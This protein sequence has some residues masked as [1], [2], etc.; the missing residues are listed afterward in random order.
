MSRRLHRRQRGRLSMPVMALIA[1]VT[2][3]VCATAIACTYFLMSGNA[4]ADDGAHSQ[5]ESVPVPDPVFVA[6]KPLTINLAGDEGR[7]LYVGMSLM[8]DNS[9]AAERVEAYMPQIRDR[10]LAVL[11]EQRAA[12]LVT[13]DGKQAL[14]ESLRDNVAAPL[15]DGEDP[16]PVTRVLFTDFIVQ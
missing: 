12:D 2:L 6:I 9:E 8:V 16:L 15:R 3:L 7:V 10:M 13:S 4:N 14:A 5:A 11:G 1:G